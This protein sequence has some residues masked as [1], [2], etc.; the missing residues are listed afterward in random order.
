MLNEAVEYGSWNA[1]R[2]RDDIRKKNGIKTSEINCN[3]GCY[4]RGTE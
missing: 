2:K 1:Y 3:V 4:L